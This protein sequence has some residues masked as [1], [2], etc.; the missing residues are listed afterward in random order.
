MRTPVPARHLAAAGGGKHAEFCIGRQLREVA[1]HIR[2]R[3]DETARRR[4]RVLEVFA[5]NDETA[6]DRKPRAVAARERRAFGQRHAGLGFVQARGIDDLALD[7]DA[8]RLFGDCLDHKADQPVAVIGIFEACVGLDDGRRLQVGHQ[9]L[10]AEERPA[11]GKLSGRGAV[12]D[13][14]G[15]VGE[16]LRDGGFRH[17]AVQ[18]LDILPDRI[19]EPQFALFA[20]LHDSGRGKALRMRGDPKPVARG[21]LFAGFEIGVA[22]RMFGDDLAAIRD[23]DDAAGLLRRPHLKL[24]PTADIVDRGLLPGFHVRRPLLILNCQLT[25]VAC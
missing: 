17:L 19:V 7:P 20:Q 6:A 13:K 22:E 14:A 1:G 3:A 9:F 12:A 4:D 5:G 24:E 25:S 2:R 11:V 15:A 10:G 16:N 23:R 21:Q 8:I 18:A